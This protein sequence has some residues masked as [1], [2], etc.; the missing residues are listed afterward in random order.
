MEVTKMKKKE[1]A[2]NIMRKVAKNGKFTI[3]EEELMNFFILNYNKKGTATEPFKNTFEQYN[4][5]DNVKKDSE[6]MKK[7]Y[8]YILNFIQK[9]TR[10]GKRDGAGRRVG[11]K[12]DKVLN[13][14]CTAE[15]RAELVRMLNL[16][17]EEKQM[18]TTAE[19]LSLALSYC[20]D[21]IVVKKEESE[22][23]ISI[24]NKKYKELLEQEEFIFNKY[25][26]LNSHNDLFTGTKEQMLFVNDTKAQNSISDL[27]YMNDV[28][29]NMMLN[30]YL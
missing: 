18:K 26:W 28:K 3:K 17:K 13:I 19:T 15:E 11:N 7:V 16:I 30:A 22:I 1:I 21:L 20:W 23:L 2:V 4:I 6:Q 27:D 9:E 5:I 24:T 14:K 8:D 12:R 29:H 10:G 25:I